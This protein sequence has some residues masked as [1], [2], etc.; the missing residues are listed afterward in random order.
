MSPLMVSLCL[1]LPIMIVSGSSYDEDYEDELPP[2]I[3]THRSSGRRSRSGRTGSAA[4]PEPIIYSMPSDNK[5]SKSPLFFPGTG[6]GLFGGQS[7]FGP[8]PARTILIPTSSALTSTPC[9]ACLP[10]A[11]TSGSLIASPSFTASG[12]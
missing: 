7:I 2:P 10:A 9:C 4:S 3:T 11:S 12:I 5:P 8:Q 1:I 6:S